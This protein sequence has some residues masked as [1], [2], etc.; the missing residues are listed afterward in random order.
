M[1]FAIL[2]LNEN[3]TVWRSF[4]SGKYT[5]S[6]NYTTMKKL[7]DEIEKLNKDTEIQ[8]E[9]AQQYFKKYEHLLEF[10]KE[11]Q[12]SESKV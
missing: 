6:Q 8:L 3:R 2:G 9:K 7:K 1:D 10:K 11:E 4:F 12:N 5:E